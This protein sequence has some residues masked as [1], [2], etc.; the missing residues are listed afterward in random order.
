MAH[1]LGSPV[2]ACVQ[3]VRAAGPPSGPSHVTM[4]PKIG[5]GSTHVHEVDGGERRMN[6][7]RATA[8]ARS[9]VGSGDLP[10]GAA[11]VAA[12]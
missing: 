8:V 7:V 11:Q 5:T 12:P 2:R 3:T 9:K 6:Q 10:S 1:P 4:W